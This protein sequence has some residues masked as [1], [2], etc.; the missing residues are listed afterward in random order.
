MTK[1]RI[2]ACGTDWDANLRHIKLYKNEAAQAIGLGQSAQVEKAK[3]QQAEAE[4]EFLKEEIRA[5]APDYL[6]EVLQL[7]VKGLEHNYSPVLVYD[8]KHY[9]TVMTCLKAYGGPRYGEGE[10]L[11]I[12]RCTLALDAQLKA[13][14]GKMGLDFEA[15]IARRVAELKALLQPHL[16]APAEEGEAEGSTVG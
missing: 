4:N 9:S 13:L 12:H 3:I 7:F 15:E 10:A 8:S 1:E 14:L 11:F 16:A 2:D 5:L 6:R